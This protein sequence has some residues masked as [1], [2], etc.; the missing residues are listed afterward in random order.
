MFIG[1]KEILNFKDLSF[2]VYVDGELKDV[3][4]LT[5]E[6]ALNKFGNISEEVKDRIL[7]YD[8]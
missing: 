2:T 1:V 7:S 6:E 5:K 3:I 8:K 4:F